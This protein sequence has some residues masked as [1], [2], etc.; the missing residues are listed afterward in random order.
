MC[1]AHS[2]L[3]KARKLSARACFSRTCI[4]EDQHAASSSQASLTSPGT[5]FLGGGPWW[6]A[7]GATYKSGSGPRENKPAAFFAPEPA[8]IRA[9]PAFASVL[10]CREHDSCIAP[11][12]LDRRTCIF[13]RWLGPETRTF[14]P[15]CKR[16]IKSWMLSSSVTRTCSLL[17]LQEGCL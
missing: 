13:S 10:I 1:H 9:Q 2:Y 6:E 14:E 7:K 4:I 8:S 12:V 3:E 16:G 17:E 5:S 15:L 11:S